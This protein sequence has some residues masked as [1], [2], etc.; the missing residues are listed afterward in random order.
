MESAKE[1]TTEVT[2]LTK[3][4]KSPAKDQVEDEGIENAPGE[5]TKE[6]TTPKRTIIIGPDSLA[7]E[8]VKEKQRAAEEELKE[9]QNDQP[10]SS[11]KGGSN[12]RNP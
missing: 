10:S 4:I 6:A 8:I 3:E 9:N 1:N 12:R 2:K 5:K 7:S 11:K